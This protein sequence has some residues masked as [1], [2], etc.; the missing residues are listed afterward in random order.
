M[1]QLDLAGPLI[2]D[3]AMGTELLARSGGHDLPCRLNLLAPDLVRAVHH[4]YVSAGAQLLVAN[5]LGAS[6]EE[7]AAGV[8]LAR[9]AVAGALA[10]T[11]A[12]TRA[13]LFGSL[14]SSRAPMP[15]NVLVAGSLSSTPPANEAV[16][17]ALAD[18]DLLIVETATSL[19]SLRSA[20]NAV[21]RVSSQPLACTLSFDADMT[22]EGLRPTEVA[23]EVGG[24][25]LAAFGYGCGFGPEASR[26]VMA[27]LRQAAP[28]AVLIAKPNLGLPNNGAYGV[29]PRQ[30]AAWARDMAALGVRIIG[31]CC[32]STPAHIRAIS[33]AL[34]WRTSTTVRLDFWTGSQEEIS[35]WPKPNW[36]K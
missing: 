11:R 12:G 6:P 27:E 29:T 5:T 23:D 4:E 15:F 35:K 9:E 2:A 7:A 34:L 32:G 13:S 21:R 26:S 8:R 33:Q 31:A 24:L 18:A 10:D 19:Q 36:K 22:V 28:N 25:A 1:R 16:V 20:V 30:L 14:D 17:A 3:G